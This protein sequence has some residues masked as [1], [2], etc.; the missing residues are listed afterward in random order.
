MTERHG[1]HSTLMEHIRQLSTAS[2][3]LWEGSIYGKLL[4]HMLRI[5]LQ[6]HLAPIRESNYQLQVKK[7]VQR[8]EERAK[9]P[10]LMSINHW[11]LR[12]IKLCD[13]LSDVLRGDPPSDKFSPRIQTINTALLSIKAQKPTRSNGNLPRVEQQLAAYDEPT[14]EADNLTSF[15]PK[16]HHHE[17]SSSARLR[18]LQAVLKILI[19][20]PKIHHTIDAEW[21]RK[22]G[23]NGSDFT[24]HECDVV[25]YLTNLFRPYAPKRTLSA[26]GSSYDDHLP[27][28]T[29]RAPMVL[30]AISTLH[31]TGYSKFIH[32]VS[33]QVSTGKPWALCLI[34]VGMYDVFCKKQPGHFDIQD[35]FGSRITDYEVITSLPGNK[36]S[37]MGSFFNME[38]VDQICRFHGLAFRNRIT[39]IDEYTI[40]LTGDVLPNGDQRKGYPIENQYENRK[41][42][43]KKKT[44]SGSW[45]NRFLVSGLTKEHVKLKA[46]TI[47]WAKKTKKNSCKQSFLPVKLFRPVHHDSGCRCTGETSR[48]VVGCHVHGHDIINTH[49]VDGNYAARN[50]GP[51]T[52]HNFSAL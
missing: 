19:E 1:K 2:N 21:V 39:F 35:A 26:D 24:D 6:L 44:Q 12:V 10:T 28:V 41:K 20:S 42:Q 15:V 50:Y 14:K 9:M 27:H 29:L 51:A 23:F 52:S 4:G 3:N 43:Q 5:L 17:D 22:M 48:R 8:K 45:R 30:I 7:A 37:V 16:R 40:R 31:A 49:L 11:K 32:R 46:E 34:A 47:T 13:D 25:A 36:R 38:K 33:P 18:P